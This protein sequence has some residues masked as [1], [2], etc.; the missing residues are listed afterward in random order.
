MKNLNDWEAYLEALSPVSRIELGLDRV[1]I[2]WNRLSQNYTPKV[3][4]IAGTNGKGSAVEAVGAVAKYLG[5]RCGQYTSPHLRSI[6]ERVRVDGRFVTDTEFIR[7]FENVESVRNGVFL[8]YFEYLTLAAFVVFQQHSLDLWVLEIGLGGRLDAVNIIEPDVSV[9]TTIGL[10]HQQFLGDDL[11]SIAYEKAGVM[12][13]GRTTWTNASN[14]AAILSETARERSAI[15]RFMDEVVERD[16]IRL[17]KSNVLIPQTDLKLPGPSVALAC[18]AMDSLGYV[19]DANIEV[20]IRSADVPGRMSSYVIDD[21]T[22]IL[23]V[24]H[25]PQACEF[26]TNT[27]SKRVPRSNRVVIFGALA[28]KDASTML[29]ILYKYTSKI[30]LVGIDGVRGRSIESLGIQWNELFEQTPWRTFATLSD[31]LNGLPSELEAEDQIMVFGSFIL[32]ADALR[33]DLFN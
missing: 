17:P 2:V 21:R 10:D 14:M 26:V 3:L 22:W 27:L 5:L 4:T 6:N 33:H 9:I 24:G 1:S 12:R 28:D 19:L 15:I 29:A 30:A 18:L 23:D 31:A 11:E 25:N 13:A 32:V 20:V 7:A 8:T 16:Q